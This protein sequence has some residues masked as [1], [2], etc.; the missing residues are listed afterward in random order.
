[1]TAIAAGDAHTLGLLTN[2]TVVAWGSNSAGQVNVPSNLFN[3]VGIA[4]GNGYGA[5]LKS[6]G[7]V[8]VWG[9]NTYGVCN[10]PANATG[11]VKIV[12]G[13]TDILALRSDETVVAWGRD[14]TNQTD[15]PA[16]LSNVV[17]L[18]SGRNTSTAVLADGTTV[19]WPANTFLPNSLSGVVSVS[20]RESIWMTNIYLSVAPYTVTEGTSVGGQV[21]LTVP[22]P[23]G[24]ATVHLLAADASIS[25]PA[26]VVVPAGAT[27][28][29]FPISSS[30]K[31]AVS[32]VT[33]VTATY[34]T[35]S[36][37]A[38]VTVLPPHFASLTLSTR[39]V[40]TGSTTQ[41][42][43]TV[44]LSGPAQK[45][46]VVTLTSSDP[47]FSVPASATIPVGATSATFIVH[48][49]FLVQPRKITLTATAEGI[50][51]STS[52]LALPL[53]PKTLTLVNFT[54]PGGS[55]TTATLTLTAVTASDAVV[56]LMAND[57]VSAPS[58]VTVPK[59]S[60]SVKFTVSTV[61]VSADGGSALTAVFNG[62]FLTTGVAVNAPRL[63]T[64]RVSPTTV[65]G[66]AVTTATVALTSP[67]PAGGTVVNLDETH[68]VGPSSVTIPEG[69]TTVNVSYTTGN[70]G[71]VTVATLTGTLGSQ[72]LSAKAT[73]LPNLP[74]TV[75]FSSVTVK[76]GTSLT[77]TVTLDAPANL[78]EFVGLSCSDSSVVGIPS[79]VTIPTGSSSVSFT[80]T[81]SAVS[82][83]RNVVITATRAGESVS[84]TLVVTK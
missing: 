82:S 70:V 78:D 15:V 79:A 63:A 14:N 48:Q 80:I 28:A 59:G 60:S 3:V 34:G 32:L 27:T 25:V 49:T 19:N 20:T 36:S 64:V 71:T 1:V 77:G 50:T 68:L 38:M 40:T 22:A 17:G 58:Q 33:S 73:V 84:R 46:E 18:A 76:G 83:T 39:T 43:G 26:T 47:D 23:A 72:S 13:A 69:Q 61:P 31:S 24:G 57:P 51:Q 41:V 37:T 29:V 9:D 52:L 10:V 74:H 12:G 4:A 44:S 35:G 55:S 56:T 30:S 53:Q 2:G 67:A 8:V 45:K 65:Y 5:A 81:T 54:I 6:D 7:T 42:M 75:T 66:G 11:I 16:G 62:V 21:R